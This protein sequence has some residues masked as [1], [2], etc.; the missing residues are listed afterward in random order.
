MIESLKLFGFLL[1]GWV[2]HS[3]GNVY[4]ADKATSEKV[5]PADV[6]WADAEKWKT[7]GSILTLAL[8]AFTNSTQVLLGILGVT[9]GGMGDAWLMFALIGYNV[10]SI[11]GKLFAMGRTKGE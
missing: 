10:D 2:I 5:G 6:L 1:I 9:V 11:A 7:L 3:L 8:L 4:E